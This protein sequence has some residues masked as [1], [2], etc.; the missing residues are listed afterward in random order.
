MLKLKT[1][2]APGRVTSKESKTVQGTNVFNRNTQQYKNYSIQCRNYK[3]TELHVYNRGI[4]WSA[5]KVA[6]RPH[7][8]GDDS[9]RMM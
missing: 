9:F 1:I 5:N 4:I 3:L 6:T 8:H 7:G 2:D